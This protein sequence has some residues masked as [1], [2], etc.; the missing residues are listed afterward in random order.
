MNIFLDKSLPKRTRIILKI[1]RVLLLA[2]LFGG[3]YYASINP[4]AGDIFLYGSI[5]LMVI[6]LAVKFIYERRRKN[7]IVE[8]RQGTV[9][10]STRE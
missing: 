9:P 7:S 2:V 1:V 5:A 10:E 8:E 3:I 6:F 4:L